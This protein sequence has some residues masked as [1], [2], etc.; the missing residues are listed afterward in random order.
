ME[1]H[2]VP[3]NI[4][5][6]QFR[7]VGDMTLKQF[8]YLAGGI[9]IG[10]LIIKFPL[11][12]FLTW[13]L[14]AIIV[15]SGIAF[16]FVPIQER[17]LDR[18]LIAFIK[19][20]Y[21]PTQF[22]WR[23]N[24]PP[25]SLLMHPL[26]RPL[27]VAPASQNINHQI[28]NQK[29]N[30]YLASLPQSLETSV[31]VREKAYITKTLSLFNSGGYAST[32]N[33]QTIPPAPPTPPLIKQDLPQSHAH[34][35][36]QS[37]NAPINALKTTPITAPI[38]FKSEQKVTT[39]NNIPET[40]PIPKKMDSHDQLQILEQKMQQLLTEKEK[41]AK[42]LFFLKQK[43]KEEI[44]SSPLM[45]VTSPPTPK[46]E[47]PKTL[48]DLTAMPNMSTV[49]NIIAGIVRDNLKRLLPGI[50]VTVKDLS[51]MPMRAFKTN[52]LGQFSAATPLASGH[53][54]IEI[55]DPLKRYQFDNIEINLGGS[56]F[57][58]IEVIAKGSREILR[59]K[60]NKE[61]FGSQPM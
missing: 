13:P 21:S 35:Q 33:S 37:I 12:S 11:P 2:P 25:L 56:I 9:V 45:Q 52:K 26:G 28:A 58:P 10:Y 60:L 1:Q 18:W 41:L 32:P 23:K 59:D 51:G 22:I 14:G 36:V 38:P 29:L 48:P 4:S 50:I 43:P 31:N 42:E 39:V 3:R 54:V 30:E 55:E 19:S 46:L 27:A 34:I 20:I 16:A 57:T 49:G 44:K 5:G 6:F 61:L 8:G 47:T 17:P 15:L 7:L 40:P 24:N 53:Y